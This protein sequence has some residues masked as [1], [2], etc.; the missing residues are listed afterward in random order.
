MRKFTARRA[1]VRAATVAVA[2]TVLLGPLLS[3]AGAEPASPDQLAAESLPAELVTA[4][5]R[6]LKMTPAEYL[7][8]SAKAQQLRNYATDFRT[9]RPD[10]FA[11]AW[12]GTD[13]KP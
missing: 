13:G 8:R 9:Q 3:T 4:I 1:T 6:D 5:Q 7:D 11:G 10:D 12:M 2:S